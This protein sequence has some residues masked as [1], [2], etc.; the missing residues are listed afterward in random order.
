MTGTNWQ[1]ESDGSWIPAK[2]LRPSW[3]VRLELWLRSRR[4]AV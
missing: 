1:M 3:W 2:P 4:R